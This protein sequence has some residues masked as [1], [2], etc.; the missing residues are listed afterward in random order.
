MNI[1]SI[2]GMNAYTANALM[3]NTASEQNNYKEATG[4]EPI[5]KSPQAS[6]E[7]FQVEIT[8]QALTLQA[9]NTE[10]PVKKDQEQTAEQIRQTPQTQ[11]L[12]GRQGSQLDVI[13]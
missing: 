7:A 4:V 10:D 8:Q 12:P 3:T 1:D 6:Q 13:A 5:E 2:Q 9:Q 11:S